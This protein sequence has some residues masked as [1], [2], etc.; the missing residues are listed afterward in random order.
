MNLKIIA[1]AAT[2]I[3]C[4]RAENEDNYFLNGKIYLAGMSEPIITDDTKGGIYAVCDG[5]GGEENGGLA[6]QIAVR[7]LSEFFEEICK[8]GASFENAI[9][10]Y[11]EN[12]NAKICEV[13]K[14]KNSGR[15]GTTFALLYICDNFAYM[16]NIGDSRIYLYKKPFMRKRQFTQISKD[17][18]QAEQLIA[19][20]SITAEEAKTHPSRNKLTQ[21][22]GIFPEEMIIEPYIPNPIKIEK[23]DTFLLCSDGLTDMLTD[24]EIADILEVARD[25]ATAANQ[26]IA[27]ALHSG[28]R[29]N[30]TVVLV[31]VLSA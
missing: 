18:T 5:M 3:G 16:S 8:S 24:E 6:S 30:V 21:H 31:R 12:A 13:M 17:H 2:H 10:R 23:G 26:M 29:D 22:L 19:M 14:S 15:M 4:V 20:G 7:V 28:G 27:S 9:T 1:A 25:P 11:A